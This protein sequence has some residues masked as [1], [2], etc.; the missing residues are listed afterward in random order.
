MIKKYIILQVVRKI[1]QRTQ[2]LLPN[3]VVYY[4]QEQ[5]S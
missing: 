2:L 1:L 3:P 4:N 5:K